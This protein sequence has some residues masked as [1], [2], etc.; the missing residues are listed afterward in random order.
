MWVGS[1]RG[2]GAECS[3]P[4]MRHFFLFMIHEF[5]VIFQSL[6]YTDKNIYK[7]AC[8]VCQAA[9]MFAPHLRALTCWDT[10]ISYYSHHA[11]PKPYLFNL[12]GTHTRTQLRHYNNAFLRQYILALAQLK[13]SEATDNGWCSLRSAIFTQVLSH[14]SQSAN[15]VET[16][17]LERG[18]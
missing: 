18:F 17:L 11:K 3:L 14:G 16:I 15:R 1:R 6:Q 8:F 4:D 2:S 10:R 7:F 12:A 9:L 5:L 13:H